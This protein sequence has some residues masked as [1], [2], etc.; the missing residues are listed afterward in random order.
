VGVGK[1][2]GIVEIDGIQAFDRRR[3]FDE[4]ED[5]DAVF[6]RPLGVGIRGE[7]I[8]AGGVAHDRFDTELIRESKMSSP[9]T[10][11]REGNCSFTQ[12]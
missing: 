11:G 6:P 2:I 4:V 1:M 8:E 10:R 5:G 9:G 7:G 12:L 3:P